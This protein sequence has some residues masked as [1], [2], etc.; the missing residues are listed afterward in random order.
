MTRD[1][2]HLH[3]FAVTRFDEI[4][5]T[6]LH[7]RRTLAAGEGVGLRR[8]L[9]AAMQTGGVGRFGRRYASPRGGLWCTLVAPIAR[10]QPA[11][12]GLGLRVGFACL[13]C[14]E[15][16]IG[17]EHA[18]RV[19]FKWPN[20]VYVDGLKAAGALTEIVEAGSVMHAVIGVGVNAN[21]PADELPE[22]V[23]ENATTLRAAV[24]AGV[25]LEAMF[26]C[27]VRGLSDAIRAPESASETAARLRD[28][29]HGVGKPAGVTMP[30]GSTRHG[31][32]LGL[33]DDGRVR[34]QLPGGEFV[35]PHGAALVV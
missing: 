13:A 25:D 4:D 30:D 27:L 1:L 20:D 5:S 23:R 11:F 29:L 16:A 22:G 9:V 34:L 14:V 8:V 2:D 26:T 32:L 15:C 31:E 33:S 35:A 21:F 6:N 3:G 17:P 10:D 19:R 12:E 28:R 18:A 24:G 7:A